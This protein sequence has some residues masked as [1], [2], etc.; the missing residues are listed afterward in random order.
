MLTKESIEKF[1]SDVKALGLKFPVAAIAKETG[2]SKGNVSA[3]LKNTDP[4]E[5]FLNVFYDKFGKSLE[6]VPQ[7]TVSG[8]NNNDPV[9]NKDLSSL[10][11]SN[12]TMSRSIEKNSNSLADLVQMLKEKSVPINSGLHEVADL[13]REMLAMLKAAIVKDVEYKAA[14][15]Q[16]EG[17]KILREI[18]KATAEHLGMNKKT[19]IPVPSK[20][21]R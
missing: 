7:K 15:N 1:H 17:R 8:G 12:L 9:V 14:G 5:K 4:S 16:E 10:I 2:Y 18:N 19:D 20:K 11:E 21:N 13:Q 3:Y 6:N